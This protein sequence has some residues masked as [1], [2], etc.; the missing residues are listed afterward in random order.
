MPGRQTH[1]GFGACVGA[2]SAFAVAQRTGSGD[3]FFEGI[4]G[5]L[6]AAFSAGLPDDLEPAT[7]PSHRAFAHSLAAAGMVSSAIPTL[8]RF[9][10]ECRAPYRC[11]PVLPASNSEAINRL[12]AHLAAGFAVGL[13]VG[14]LSHLALDARTPKGLPLM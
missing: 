1:L 4:G 5:A 3:P 11:R 12:L 6:A 10:E 7:S 8:L 2:V 13:A 14:F 9:A